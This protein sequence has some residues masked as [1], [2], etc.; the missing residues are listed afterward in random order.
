[1]VLI[2]G[3]IIRT[4]VLVNEKVNLLYHLFPVLLLLLLLLFF[5][6]ER[7]VLWPRLE[8]SHF[9]TNLKLKYSY[10]FCQIIEKIYLYFL[11][12]VDRLFFNLRIFNMQKINI[13]LKES[14]HRLQFNV[15]LKFRIFLK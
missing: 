11:L 1:M 6:F 2:I 9:F 10:D 3:M 8:Y 15:F 12:R 7:I 14:Q 4:V 5:F 13:F